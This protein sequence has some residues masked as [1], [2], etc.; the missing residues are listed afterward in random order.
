MSYG[1]R[2]NL[3]GIE[4]GILDGTL[5]KANCVSENTLV[6]FSRD[7][8]QNQKV[9]WSTHFEGMP[10]SQKAGMKGLAVG[11]IDKDGAKII[12]IYDVWEKEAQENLIKTEIV[13]N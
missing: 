5:T 13:V 10:D 3:E 8:G 7:V 2:V 1:F 6:I 12:A 4:K 9:V 11:S